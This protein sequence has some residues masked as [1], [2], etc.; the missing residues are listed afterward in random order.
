MLATVMNRSIR[1]V[2]GLRTEKN[3][4]CSLMRGLQHLGRQAQKGR[5][6]RAHQHHGPF[7]QARD[8]GQKAR[9]LDHFQPVG[10]GLIGGLGPDRIGALGGVEDHAVRLSFAA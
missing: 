7:D 1:P 2:L 5:V 6:D 8:L 3:F 10:E 4:W 9:V